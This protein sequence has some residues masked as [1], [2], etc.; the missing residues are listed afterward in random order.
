MSTVTVT[1]TVGARKQLASDFEEATLTIA[2]GD[3]S[4]R[5]KGS[6]LEGSKPADAEGDK[7]LYPYIG[8]IYIGIPLACLGATVEV[9]ALPVTVRTSIAVHLMRNRGMARD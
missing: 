9:E 6:L 1:Y 5:I 2:N 7:C 4:I 8:G 3:H